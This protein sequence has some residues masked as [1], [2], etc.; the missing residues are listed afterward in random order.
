LFSICVSKFSKYIPG[1]AGGTGRQDFCHLKI[2]SK[3]S[4]KSILNKNGWVKKKG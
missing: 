2:G 4:Q 3:N 1:V